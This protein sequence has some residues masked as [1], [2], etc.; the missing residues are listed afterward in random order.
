MFSAARVVAWPTNLSVNISSSVALA[1]F[2]MMS[3]QTM[4]PNTPP[5]KTWPCDTES[6]AGG[7]AFVND[8]APCCAC[9][10]RS[11]RHHRDEAVGLLRFTALHSTSQHFTALHSTSQRNRFLAKAATVF[12]KTSKTVVEDRARTLVGTDA[13]AEVDERHDAPAQRRVRAVRGCVDGRC[14]HLRHRVGPQ[15]GPQ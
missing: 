3:A 8:G 4:R 11:L 5:R 12:G 1:R 14:A 7:G 15:P 9:C 2:F 13:G 6:D 10:A